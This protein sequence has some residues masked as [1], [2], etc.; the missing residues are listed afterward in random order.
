M[1]H[2]EHI[3]SSA[4]RYRGASG[5]PQAAQHRASCADECQAGRGTRFW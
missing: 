5:S 4:N 1:H 3:G 2:F